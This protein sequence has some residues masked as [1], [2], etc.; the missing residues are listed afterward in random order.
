MAIIITGGVVMAS[1][2]AFKEIV[3]ASLLSFGLF[4]CGMLIP[5]LALPLMLLYPFPSLVVTH[6]LGHFSGTVSVLITTAALFM[7]FPSLL[8]IV[9]FSAFGMLGVFLA[10]AAKRI[11]NSSE[12]IL[13]GVLIALACKLL[14]AFIVYSVTGSNFFAP[15]TTLLEGALVTFSDSLSSVYPAV[16][17]EIK[18][19]PAKII[20]EMVLLIPFTVILF[21]ALEVIIS[22]SLASKLHKKATGEAFFELP[23]LT[24][25]TFPQNI[26][27]A[28]IVGLICELISQKIDNPYFL[29]QI[30]LNLVALTRTLFIIQG[31][32]VACSFMEAKSFPKA[33]RIIMIVLTPLISVL[34]DMLSILGILDIGFNLRKR[35]RGS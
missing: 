33:A 30:S 29:R 35:I 5:I 19:N 7:I 1:I 2:S 4:V 22:L 14:A 18:K 20:E 28:M 34:G 21:S 25:W 17:A 27:F 26:L 12:M 6:R 8:P 10:V 9:Y 11:K 16:A 31:L 32:A 15:D 13:A 3:V 24:T 23:P